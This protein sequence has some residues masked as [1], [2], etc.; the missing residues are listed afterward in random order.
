MP[1]FHVY[2]NGVKK[3]QMVG[4]SDADFEEKM[5][6]FF[7]SIPTQKATSS[8]RVSG[9]GSQAGKKVAAKK[10]AAD[11]AAKRNRTDEK[12]AEAVARKAA[13]AATKSAADVA[14][15]DKGKI[16]ILFE[17]SPTL[18]LR[19]ELDG[20]EVSADV[21]IKAAADAAGGLFTLYCGDN[22]NSIVFDAITSPASL[23]VTI[24]QGAEK[25][26]QV[27]KHQPLPRVKEGVT[28]AMCGL[29]IWYASQ[30]LRMLF[31][32]ALTCAHVGMTPCGVCRAAHQQVR[33]AHYRRQ[34]PMSISP[35]KL[36][37]LARCACPLAKV[38]VLEAAETRARAKAKAKAKAAL[39]AM[40]VAPPKR[41]LQREILLPRRSN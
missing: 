41:R 24:N 22:G 27:P 17:H 2:L 8:Y 5:A 28:Y 31:N 38:L 6:A 21:A 18:P 16:A 29:I 40:A 34:V 39:V 25:C 20:E 36:F 7:A 35:T 23:T 15:A 14:T 37:A 30:A 33:R 11:A 10:A 9:S 32:C 13:A 3:L 19:L 26:P 4:P 12:A 1:T